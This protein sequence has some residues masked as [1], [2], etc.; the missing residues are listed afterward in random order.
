MS[1]R[2]KRLKKVETIFVIL[3]L[4]ILAGVLSMVFGYFRGN[5]AALYAGVV[6]AVLGAF[7]TV[8]FVAIKRGQALP[9]RR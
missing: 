2:K 3:G 5:N 6:V 7:N 1:N 9:A 8:V 4:I